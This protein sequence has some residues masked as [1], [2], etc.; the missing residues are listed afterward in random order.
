M[1]TES[2]YTKTA[3][4]LHWLV[5]LLIF[6]NLL[7]AWTVD[8][9]PD[10]WVRFSI[11]THKSIGIT[12]LGLVLLRVLWR[13]A[14]PP[15]ALPATF[16]NWEKRVSKLGHIALYLLMI[17]IPVSGWMH[18]SAWKDAATHPMQLF[19]LVPWPRIS[20]IAQQAPAYKET[21]HTYFGSLH[22]WL[23]IALYILFALH[24]AGVLK[25][26]FF[27]KKSVLHRM[28]PK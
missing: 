17:A 22:H 23:N 7:I 13:I 21:L 14:H 8:Y 18:D 16:A 2:K 6:G 24:M 11:N 10:E 25:H 28:L 1:V 15:P 26:Q 5:A 4:Y 19:Y 20:I 12:V 3:I 27:D 9:L